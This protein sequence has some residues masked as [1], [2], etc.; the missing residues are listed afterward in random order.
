MF[1]CLREFRVQAILRASI[2]EVEEKRAFDRAQS[3]QPAGR[4]GEINMPGDHVA[5]WIAGGDGAGERVELI[6]S[7]DC[8]AGRGGFTRYSLHAVVPDTGE[9]GLEVTV[10]E[11]SKRFRCY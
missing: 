10:T 1:E 11:L 5:R 8:P 9:Q 2:N 4:G 3:N 7:W 6:V